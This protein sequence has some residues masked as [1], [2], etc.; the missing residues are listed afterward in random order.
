M[1]RLNL[2]HLRAFAQVA[3]TGSISAASRKVF[4]SQPAITQALAKLEE[5]VGTPLFLRKSTG[6]FLTEAGELLR[7]RVDRALFILARAARRAAR[8]GGRSKSVGFAN[9]HHLLTSVQLRCFLALCETGNYSWAARNLGVSRPSVHRGINDMERISGLQLFTRS[10]QGFEPT[11]AGDAL[12]QGVLL[13]FAE[14][15]QGLE[16]VCMLLGQDTARIVLG[17]LPL[18]RSFILPKA[19]NDLCAMRPEVRIKVRDGAYKDLLHALRYG[20]MDVLIGALRDPPPVDDVVQEELFVDKLAIAARAGH[21]LAG[22]RRLRADMLAQFPWVTP[23][24]NIPTRQQFDALFQNAKV[25]APGRIVESSSLI[26]I[27]GLLLGSDRLT[28][29]SRH[30]IARELEEGVLTTLDFT[31][32]GSDRPIGI[33]TRRGWSPTAT[34]SLFLDMLRRICSENAFRMHASDTGVR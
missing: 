31:L 29:I 32:D 7:A 28:I 33:T 16:E 4:L 15:K 24:S 30:Q 9:F 14:L 25:P 12:R 23:S 3:A 11:H 17:T 2:R 27:R 18:A 21:P 26:L 22:R 34:Q 8:G 13:A 1:I 10:V 5:A 20:E 6:M 19:I